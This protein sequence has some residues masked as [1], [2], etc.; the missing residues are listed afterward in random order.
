M[1]GPRILIVEDEE[2]VRRFVRRMLEDA[3]YWVAEA[4]NGHEALEREER[5]NPDLLLVDLMAPG[6]NGRAV[7]DELTSR[8]RMVV[9]VSCFVD[10]AIA[11][12]LGAVG[13]LRKP[14]KFAEL[15][16]VCERALA[17]RLLA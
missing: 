16:T 14:F 12:R 8:G 6:R 17:A 11:R 7:V 15:L 13:F 10:E 4:E 3:G 2:D 9:V 5:L 1:V